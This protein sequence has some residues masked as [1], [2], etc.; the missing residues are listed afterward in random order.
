MKN[1][2]ITGCSRPTGF[3]QLTAKQF[4][5]NGFKVYAGLRQ[6]ERADALVQW[7][8]DNGFELETL[9]LDVTDSAQNRS[10]VAT[11][12]ESDGRL[13]VLVN[14]VGVSSFG[15]LETLRD[16]H[17][18]HTME[19]NFFSALDLTRAVLP[20]MREQGGGRVIFL[21]SL[22]G[23]MGVPGEAVYCASKYAIEGLAQALALEVRRFG[24]EV[25]T[26][27]PG[28]FN[29]GMSGE[30]TDTSSFF[31]DVEAYQDF[32]ELVTHATAEGESEG[33]EPAIVAQTIFE[34]ATS[35]A[36]K[37][38]WLPG[39]M[40]P[41]LVA[42]RREMSDADWQGFTMEQL[43]MGEWFEAQPG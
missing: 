38:H 41:A 6:R 34:A 26:V 13:D 16:D 22:A 35:P 36:P 27:R 9:E 31:D 28:F 24:I 42:A 33:E 17:I 11:I 39:E 1:V 15:A 12:L 7:A 43:A 37:P 4:A 5:E 20:A 10:A 23:V 2:L 25:S 18:R 40:A 21:S 29:T 32:N 30:N 14:N 8:R 19:T 3:G